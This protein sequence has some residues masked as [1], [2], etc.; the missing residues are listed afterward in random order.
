MK[1]VPYCK[2]KIYPERY[3]DLCANDDGKSVDVI[4][5]D[6]NGT[7]LPAGMLLNISDKGVYRYTGVNPVLGFTMQDNNQLRDN[8]HF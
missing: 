6:S 5:V 3:L 8:D 7:L 2:D 1:I 4:A